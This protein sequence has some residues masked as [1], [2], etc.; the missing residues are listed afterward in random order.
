VQVET[1]KRYNLL[2]MV[3]LVVF[4][5][6]KFFEQGHCSLSR[7]TAATNDALEIVDHLRKEQTVKSV[8]R[9]RV[10]EPAGADRGA[11][12]TTHARISPYHR[13]GITKAAEWSCVCRSNTIRSWP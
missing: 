13:S 2:E 3:V 6:M 1:A 12:I 5:H 9:A 8:S 4:S 10:E 7:L 11:G